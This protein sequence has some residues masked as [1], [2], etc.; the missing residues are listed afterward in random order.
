MRIKVARM[1]ELKDGLQSGTSQVVANIVELT[2][3]LVSDGADVRLV[4]ELSI[5]SMLCIHFA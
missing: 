4:E 3:A 2:F 5:L 1:A